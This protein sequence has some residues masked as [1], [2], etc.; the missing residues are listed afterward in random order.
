MT[1]EGYMDL[2]LSLAERWKGYTHPN[3][4]VGCVI[5]KNG[6]IVGLGYHEGAGRPHAEIVALEQA[7][8]EARDAEV[9]VTL[10]PCVHQGRTPPCTSALLKAGV[11]RVVVALTDRNPLVRGKGI[12]KLRSA[13]VE[14][15]VGV[16]EERA[17]RLNEDFFTYISS[18]RPYVTLKLAQTVDGRIA[19]PEGDSRWI[20]SEES[21]RYAHRLRLH[22]TAILVGLNTVLRDDPLLTVRHVPSLRNPLRVVVDPELCIPSD[23]RLLTDRSAPT[24]VIF[25]ERNPSREKEVRAAGAELIHLEDLSPGS[26]LRELHRRGVVHLLVEGGAYTVTEFLKA[27]LWDRLVVFEAPKLLGR[28]KGIEDLGVRRVVDALKLRLREE[29]RL[30]EERVLEFV[31]GRLS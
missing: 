24:A 3:P 20:T 8:D 15:L 30:G 22:A 13:G 12:E 23:A 10:E 21:R 18:E 27:G 9:Y 16:R 6:R 2:A 5:V 11:R 7:G 4:T 31:P 17:L 26:I 14:V 29:I 25:S 1:E 19:T 28:G